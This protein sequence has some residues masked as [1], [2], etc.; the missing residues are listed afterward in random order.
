MER[1]NVS[2]PPATLAALDTVLEPGR[3][4]A[5]LHYAARALLARIEG[6]VGDAAAYEN[7]A[8]LMVRPGVASGSGGFRRVTLVDQRGMSH[9]VYVEHGSAAAASVDRALVARSGSVG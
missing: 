5:W 7:A 6:R 3:R 1:I 9:E 8:R 2:L 4:S